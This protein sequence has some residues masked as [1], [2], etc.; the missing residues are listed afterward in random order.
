MLPSC[1][2][3][4]ALS[5]LSAFVALMMM[6]SAAM[7]ADPGLPYP[8]T[9]PVSDQHP[10]SILFFNFYTS[11][12]TMP[13]LQNSRVSITNTST[14]SSSIVHLFFVDGASCSP[15]NR[16]ICLTPNQTVSF[17]A[18]DQDPGTTGYLMALAVDSQGCPVAHNFLIGNV[19]IKMESGHQANLEADGFSA[20]YN[21]TAPGCDGNTTTFNLLFDG[22]STGTTASYDRVP[23][24]VALSKIPAVADGNDTRLIVIRVGGSL[25][26]GTTPI[27]NLFGFVF[28]DLEN[29][30]SIT[31]S[32]LP[33]QL[34]RR[35]DNNFPRTSPP[36][37]DFISSGKTGW[38][39]VYTPVDDG[40]LLGSV[41]NR[42][43][44]VASAP[45]AFVGGHNLHKLTLSASNTLTVPVFPPGCQ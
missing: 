30:H 9:S 35:I 21:G 39:K 40:G 32:G 15:S 27:G 1:K 2:F 25:L 16:F 29:P 41:L 11:S 4:R 14:T 42:N 37:E 19:F 18:S 44:N 31:L 12:A 5:A 38:L 23:R 22:N 20:L 3:T 26:T 33:C 10:G 45:N 43:V 7:A 17:L 34:V 36:L 28:D 24:V 13:N 6:A 8:S